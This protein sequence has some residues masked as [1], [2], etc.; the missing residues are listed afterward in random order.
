LFSI[1]EVQSTKAKS[2]IGLI[3]AK[4]GI[5]LEYPDDYNEREFFIWLKI[6]HPDLFLTISK[7]KKLVYSKGWMA[8]NYILDPEAIKNSGEALQKS[9][10][11][12][13]T[14]NELR[15]KRCK[16]IPFESDH[17]IGFTAHPEDHLKHRNALD[18]NSE[19]ID[20]S[21]REVFDVYFIYDTFNEQFLVKTNG[22][23]DEKEN[24]ARVFFETITKEKFDPNKRVQFNLQ[25]FLNPEFDLIKDP[26]HGLEYWGVSEIKIAYP[27]VKGK[28]ITLHNNT[29]TGENSGV[30]GI[31][32][33]YK[34]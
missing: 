29:Y 32:L 18:E 25:H 9:L 2:E 33:F 28:T 14:K 22:G 1:E 31:A 4:K 26:K 19:L 16:V 3:G 34:N 24:L 5:L 11:E 12:Y 8:Y 17:Y 10:T 23:L 15:G 27:E 20:K 7:V 21:D 30:K 6:N 13:L